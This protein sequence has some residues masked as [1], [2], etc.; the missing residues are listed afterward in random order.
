MNSSFHLKLLTGTK[1]NSQQTTKP[2]VKIMALANIRRKHNPLLVRNAL[3]RC[4][5]GESLNSIAKASGIPESSL[6]RYKMKPELN[7]GDTGPPTLLTDD[8]EMGL[9]TAALWL[10]DHG[11]PMDKVRLKK[12]A[13]YFADA[14]GVAFKAKH[15]L[16]ID[17]WF[18]TFVHR[19]S[20]KHGINL[21]LR[22]PNV[23]SRLRAAAG[24][25]ENIT[26]YY[27]LHQQILQDYSI[28]V[29]KNMGNLDETFVRFDMKHQRVITERNAK[30]I[31]PFKYCWG[32]VGTHHNFGICNI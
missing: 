23:L 21:T 1:L 15:G 30:A 10:K 25:E 24:N 32:T 18:D 8:E 6:K 20:V 13:K 11:L 4:R 16:P 31:F 17:E 12:C 3:K 7:D 19:M 26:Y 27:Q 22:I 5:K 2:R 29:S 9:A 14:R 28:D